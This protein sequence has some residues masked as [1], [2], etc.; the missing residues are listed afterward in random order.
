MTF[1]Q[2]ERTATASVIAIVTGLVLPK[3][4]FVGLDRVLLVWTFFLLYVVV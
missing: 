1:I 2:L 3:A 4:M